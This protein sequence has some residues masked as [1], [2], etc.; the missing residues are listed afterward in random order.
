MKDAGFATL[1]SEWW[2]FQDDDAI[3]TLELKALWSG[4]SAEGWKADDTGWRYRRSSGSYYKD[5]T[6][7]IDGVSYTFDA[8]GYVT[9]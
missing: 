7:T 1:V 8:Q 9:P 6:R 4:I 2:H 5:C 3:D